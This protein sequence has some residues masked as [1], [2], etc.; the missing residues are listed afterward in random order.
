[1]A[2]L[3]NG[4]S[5]AEAMAEAESDIE[6]DVEAEYM[7]DDMAESIAEA[8][9]IVLE[10]ARTKAIDAYIAEARSE[11]EAKSRFKDMTDLIDKI[12]DKGEAVLEMST[13]ILSS[14]HGEAEDEFSDRVYAKARAMIISIFEFKASFALTEMSAD[15][16]AAI[17]EVTMATDIIAQASACVNKE[18]AYEAKIRARYRA[19]LQS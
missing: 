7:D 9:T 14:R 11:V 15:I 16:I 12:R 18:L 19:R 8:E 10:Q 2:D 4:E 1:M 13:S 3:F 5:M 17:D 6:A